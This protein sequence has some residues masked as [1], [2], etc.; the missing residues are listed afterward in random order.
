MFSA[1][2]FPAR[3]DP[4]G[5]DFPPLLFQ[6]REVI[7][8]LRPEPHFGAAAEG[9]G[10]P[11]RHLRGDPGL[12]V[13]DVIERLAGYSKGVRGRDAAAFSCRYAEWCSA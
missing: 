10:K 9:F 3:E 5:F 4:P 11:D 6:L 2:L 1:A 12:E 13:H 8:G 7:G